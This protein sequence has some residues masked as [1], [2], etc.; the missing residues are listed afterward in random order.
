MTVEP[1]R[2][3]CRQIDWKKFKARR[4][5]RFDHVWSITA[6]KSF[7][8]IVATFSQ[9]LSYQKVYPRGIRESVIYAQLSS[10][11]TTSSRLKG[12]DNDLTF[13]GV[14]ALFPNRDG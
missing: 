6:L 9:G 2:I 7:C 5:A 11:R 10:K 12:G 13:L 1:I 3:Y 14:F 4:N 8:E